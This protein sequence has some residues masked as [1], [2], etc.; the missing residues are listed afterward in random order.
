[1]PTQTNKE[2]HQQLSADEFSS[3][4]DSLWKRLSARLFKFERLQSYQEPDNPSFQAFRDGN[5]ERAEREMEQARSQD[6][7]L[8]IEACRKDIAMVRVRAVELPLS[9]YLSWEFKTYKISARYGERI[10]IA[11]F[12]AEDKS[13]DVVSAPD[14]ILF[15]SFAVLIPEYDVD[16]LLKGARLIEGGQEVAKFKTIAHKLLSLSVPLA[17]FERRHG[18]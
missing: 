1:M 11:D 13:D 6:A 5:M 15:D 10:L 3:V 16:G 9:L 8:Y 18:L 7:E 2:T 17:I 4:F 12:T 14:F